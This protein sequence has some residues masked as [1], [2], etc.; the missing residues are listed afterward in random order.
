M[1]KGKVKRGYSDR[2]LTPGV[3]PIPECRSSFIKVTKLKTAMR[4]A[5]I[6]T[7]METKNHWL[8]YVLDTSLFNKHFNALVKKA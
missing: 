6:L 8:V 1:E 7:Y 4:I 5:G 2:I 3:V